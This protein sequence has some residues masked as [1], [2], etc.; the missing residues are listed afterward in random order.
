[1]LV[2]VIGAMFY[3][4]MKLARSI[5]KNAP[6]D[7]RAKLT[8][9]GTALYACMTSVLVLFVA[10]AILK[11]EGALGSFLGTLQGVV[12]ALVGTVVF[13]S[14]AAWL[15]DRFGYPISQRAKSK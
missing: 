14:I 11:P 10:A 7:M 15:F 9:T 8:L 4:G 2:L 12:V 1:V 5:E 13:F 3:F 6:R